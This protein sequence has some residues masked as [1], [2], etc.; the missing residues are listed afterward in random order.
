MKDRMTVRE[1]AKAYGTSP[2]RVRPMTDAGEIP[3]HRI[4]EY[5]TGKSEARTRYV[6]LRPM[7]AADLRRRG[8]LHAEHNYGGAA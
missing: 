8:E 2:H 6:Y 7:I 4:E 3:F 1:V 5:I